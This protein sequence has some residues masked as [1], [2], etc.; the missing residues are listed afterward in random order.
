MSQTL[1]SQARQK[2]DRF[3]SNAVISPTEQNQARIFDNINHD[4]TDF[5]NSIS[6]ENAG[7]VN[8][9]NYFNNLASTNNQTLSSTSQYC[10]PENCRSRSSSVDQPIDVVSIDQPID[11]ENFIS[12][13]DAGHQTNC[14]NNLPSTNTLLSTSQCNQPENCRSRSSSVDQPIDVEN[15]IPIE[16]AGQINETNCLNNLPSTNNQTLSSISQCYQP[17]NCR[18]RSSSVSQ[19]REV[20]NSISIENVGQNNQISFFN[21]RSSGSSRQTNHL[22]V[23]IE[24]NVTN[25]NQNVN[26]SVDNDNTQSV[27]SISTTSAPPKKR[28]RTPNNKSNVKKRKYFECQRC[29]TLFVEDEEF[30][31]HIKILNQQGN[32]TS[33]TEILQ[34]SST[35]P[36][37]YTCHVC[38][39]TF[40]NVMYFECHMQTH[41]EQINHKCQICNRTFTSIYKYDKH[42]MFHTLQMKA[43]VNPDV[44]TID[45]DDE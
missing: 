41:N 3:D 19:T 16:D 18:S 45:D 22:T 1:D 35:D 30:K 44:I 12:I 25:L 40:T 11:V 23:T 13:E 28:K 36:K 37:Q 34:T 14:C 20:D 27:I 15:L 24:T 7:Q 39:K 31:E 5:E 17:E 4:N 38:L 26:Y 29:K 32:C 21:I 9:T 42:M 10:Q 8:Q 33:S 2:I 6:I 43:V